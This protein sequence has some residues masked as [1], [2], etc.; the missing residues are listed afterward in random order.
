M[1]TQFDKLSDLSAK[2]PLSIVDLNALQNFYR[3]NGFTEFD[4]HTFV[5]GND[6]QTDIIEKC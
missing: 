2:F 5:V 1:L 6:A 3:K 4:K